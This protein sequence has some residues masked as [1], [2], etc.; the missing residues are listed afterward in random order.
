[1]REWVQGPIQ[2]E[3]RKQSV[4]LGPYRMTPQGCSHRPRGAGPQLIEA[5][6]E[7]RFTSLSLAPPIWDSP[8]KAKDSLLGKKG[9]E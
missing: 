4:L 9:D 1:M 2:A 5:L 7:A 8:A 6:Q 3:K